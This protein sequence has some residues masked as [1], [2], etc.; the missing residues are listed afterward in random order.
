M[1]IEFQM[2]RDGYVFLES[3]CPDEEDAVV[4]A[5]LGGVLTLS[6]GSA[7]HPLT[8]MRR[9]AATPNTYSGIYGYERFPF[10]TDLAHWR[11][12]PRYLILR[13]EVGFIE[14]R[15]HANHWCRSGFEMVGWDL[16]WRFDES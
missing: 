11:S 10:H 3:Y 8:P 15:R 2:R 16:G 13:C 9:E 7:I 12:P 1:S 5:S 6:N 14:V 4:A